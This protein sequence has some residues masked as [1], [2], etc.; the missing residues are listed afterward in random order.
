MVPNI[1]K[2][3]G[4]TSLAV[5][6]SANSSQN[7]DFR[8]SYGLKL[9]PSLRFKDFSLSSTIPIKKDSGNLIPESLNF[10]IIFCPDNSAELS[11]RLVC[12]CISFDL[13]DEHFLQ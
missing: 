1:I 11:P 3:A 12:R 2:M 4:G 10:F 8:N 6:I 9:C 13:L 7:Y 5:F